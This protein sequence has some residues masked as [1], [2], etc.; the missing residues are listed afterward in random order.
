MSQ[1]VS[2]NPSW[3]SSTAQALIL[4]AFTCA[5]GQADQAIP[6]GYAE[7]IGSP[8]EILIPGQLRVADTEALRAAIAD[9][10]AT[11]ISAIRQTPLLGAVSAWSCICG[12]MLQL[13]AEELLQAWLRLLAGGPEH[14]P[15]D[16]LSLNSA[17]PDLPPNYEN[18]VIFGAAVEGCR[19]AVHDLGRH[20]ADAADA[21]LRGMLE[22]VGARIDPDADMP[23][24]GDPRLS[25]RFWPEMLD[26]S[27]LQSAFSLGLGGQSHQLTCQSEIR[28]IWAEL[29]S[30]R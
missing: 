4:T 10:P 25:Y 29:H 6:E 8:Y 18:A 26:N 19:L 9:D 12:R 24:L 3:L 2:M 15:G 7:F 22:T 27:S 11:W 17:G 16:W 5:T 1:T 30:I 21:A 28:D 14:E 23:A 13:E 20:D